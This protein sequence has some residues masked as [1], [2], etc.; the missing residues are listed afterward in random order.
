M[1]EVT[2]HTRELRRVRAARYRAKY[3]EKERERSRLFTAKRRSKDP[4]H[5]AEIK[6]K[7]AAKKEAFY[8]G[9]KQKPCMDCGQVFPSCVMEFDHVRGEKLKPVS[10]LRVSKLS[11]LLAEVAKCDLVCSN[12]HRMRTHRTTQAEELL[13]LCNEGLDTM[14]WEEFSKEF[15]VE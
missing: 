9:L 3:P 15:G 7:S 8:V 11:T 5:M 13:R 6:A 2:E 12:C 14:T 4:A 1:A 10:Q